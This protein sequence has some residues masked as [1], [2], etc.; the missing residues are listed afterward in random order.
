MFRWSHFPRHLQQTPRVSPWLVPSKTCITV[1][2]ETSKLTKTDFLRFPDCPCYNLRKKKPSLFSNLNFAFL[3]PLNFPCCSWNPHPCFYF[4]HP[5]IAYRHRNIKGLSSALPTSPLLPP[6]ESLPTLSK[7][8][9]EQGKESCRPQH[10][11]QTAE[12]L[13]LAHRGHLGAI[14]PGALYG[15]ASF[16]SLEFF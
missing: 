3:H 5:A 12:Q 7:A 2:V 1:H 16:G 15:P 8:K 11:L 6:R 4:I 14:T 10:Q 9:E 13:M